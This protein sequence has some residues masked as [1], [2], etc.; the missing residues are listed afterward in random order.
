MI[1]IQKLPEAPQIWTVCWAI[2]SL[3]KVLHPD[4]E[5]MAY[6]AYMAY[7]SRSYSLP[8]TW[9]FRSCILL[10]TLTDA[11][12]PTTLSHIP[13]ICFTNSHGMSHHFEVCTVSEN[14]GLMASSTS[15]IR[16]ESPCQPDLHTKKG[17]KSRHISS[18]PSPP[19]QQIESAPG[20]M[21]STGTSKTKQFKALFGVTNTLSGL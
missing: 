5:D 2:E 19:S 9:F 16:G 20:S 21:E 3:P 8:F 10:N 18:T 6:M 11:P 4:L 1:Q 14:N 13:P 15:D 17:R 12:P 7:M